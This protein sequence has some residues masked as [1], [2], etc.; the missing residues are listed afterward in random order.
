MLTTDLSLRFDP[1]YG[2]ISKRFHE[3]PDEFALAFAKA[4]Y[5]LTHRDMGPLSR[6]LGPE[7]PSE[8]Q[9]WQDPVPAVDHELVNEADIADLK[10]QILASGLSVSQLVS[11][12]W[13]S[14]AS[15]R[16][17]DMRGGANGGRIR[18]APQ[19]TWE[20]NQP[21]ELMPV[22]QGLTRIQQAFNEH[23][24]GNK[25]VSLADLIVLGG[26]AGIEQ[27]A[28]AAGHE[29]TVPFAPGRTDATQEQTDVDSFAVLEPT[30]DGFRNYVRAGQKLPAE[31]LLVERAHLL[32]LSAPEMTVLV[33][34]LRVLG[35]NHGGS[36]HGVLTNRP[37]TLSNDF[38][39]NLLD[40]GT[41]WKASATAE[42]A[43]DGTDRTSGETRWTG[44]AVDL[45][46]GSNS[47]LRALAEV[48]ACS[49]AGQKFVNDFVAAWVKVMN[50]DRFDLA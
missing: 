5:K 21:A 6:Y 37:G 24:S 33:G 14:A 9:I 28:R 44:T 30:F 22:L 40:M 31:H 47:Q 48:Y 32:N 1:I 29:V 10:A 39:V 13:A 50:A 16:G 43:F 17:T 45:V 25:Q 8:P 38:F 3:N 42:G 7:V 35:A 4:W 36:A 49:D 2:P 46:F 19:N 20:V 12:A 27:A 18:L 26:S 23:Q 34:G 11:T 41:E 15:F